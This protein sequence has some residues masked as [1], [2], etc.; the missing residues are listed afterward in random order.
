MVRFEPF[1]LANFNVEWNDILKTGINLNLGENNLLDEDITYISPNNSRI[2]YIPD[3]LR[4]F[5]ITLRYSV[6]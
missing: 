4:E 3:N 6:H 1:V 2:L 5:I